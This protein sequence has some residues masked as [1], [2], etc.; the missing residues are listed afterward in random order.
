MS[1]SVT[2]IHT[3]KANKSVVKSKI[4]WS[5]LFKDII[6]R[7]FK[8]EHFNMTAENFQ[9]SSPTASSSFFLICGEHMS[10]N[11]RRQMFR[12]NI[13]VDNW[14][15]IGAGVGT[16]SPVLTINNNDPRVTLAGQ[17]TV[18]LARSTH[19]KGLFNHGGASELFSRTRD[20][21]D[22]E[23]METRSL[24]RGDKMEGRPPSCSLV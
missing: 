7:S 16:R 19:R 6:F 3:G 24:A 13:A 14:T 20:D 17:R 9:F 12:T 21:N 11:R 8:T 18:T 23:E 15:K 1:D 4:C 5:K 10:E 2:Y 22:K